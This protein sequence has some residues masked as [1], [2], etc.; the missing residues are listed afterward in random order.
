MFMFCGTTYHKIIRNGSNFNKNGYTEF[1]THTWE[2]G[3]PDLANV[4]NSPLKLE[5]NLLPNKTVKNQPMLQA[6]M[7]RAA[8][9]GR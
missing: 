4:Y 3:V 6:T 2:N 8:K 5:P 1:I 7:V 9:L